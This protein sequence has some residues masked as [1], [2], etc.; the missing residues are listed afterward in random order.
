LLVILKTLSHQISFKTAFSNYSVN[1]M[2]ES[3]TINIQLWNSAGQEEYKRFIP[4]SYT[5]TNFFI[6]GFII[7]SETTLVNVQEMLISKI[8]EH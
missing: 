8:R 4:L 5:D 2:Y 3:Q 6:V 1:G 7:K